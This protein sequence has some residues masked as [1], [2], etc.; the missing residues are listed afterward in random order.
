MLFCVVHQWM[1][2]H[3]TSHLENKRGGN[4]QWGS[5]GWEAETCLHT[6]RSIALIFLGVVCNVLSHLYVFCCGSDG[7]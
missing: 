7:I 4:V 5:G 3:T 2:R 6:I 1:Q